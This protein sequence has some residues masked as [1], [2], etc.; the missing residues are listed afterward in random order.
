MSAKSGASV[1]AGVI[2]VGLLM[3]E[4]A[5]GVESKAGVITPRVLEGLANSNSTA[6]G[7]GGGGGEAGSCPTLK[8]FSSVT[9]SAPPMQPTIGFQGGGY[10]SKFT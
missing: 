4:G 3:V 8:G 2:A 9:V 5:G 7:S 1:L 6:G 10:P